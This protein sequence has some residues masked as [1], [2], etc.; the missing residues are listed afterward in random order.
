MR[1]PALYTIDG[2]RVPSVTKILALSGWSRWDHIPP[3]VLARAAERGHTVHAFTQL[4]D[5]GRADYDLLPGDWH[6]YGRA[7]ERFLVETRF[8][9]TALEEIVKNPQHR[10]CGTLDRRG[11]FQG[12][13]ILDIKTSEVLSVA[14]PLQLAAYAGCFD[15][16]RHRRFVLRLNRTGAYK[17]D[18]CRSPL[19][20]QRFQ[21]A[22]LTVNSQIDAGLIPLEDAHA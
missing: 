21:A 15:A 8:R 3:E 10:Y 12:P 7:Y 22:A 13:A 19:D 18:E 4:I 6:G 1:D 9:V 14:T 2:K 20:W 17:L 11:E 16:P 5:E